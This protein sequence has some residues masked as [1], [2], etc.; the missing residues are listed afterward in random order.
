MEASK[1][2]EGLK[3]TYLIGRHLTTRRVNPSV[4]VHY[5]EYSLVNNGKHEG[6]LYMPCKSNLNYLLTGLFFDWKW[7]YEGNKEIDKKDFDMLRHIFNSQKEYKL[8]RDTMKQ[9]KKLKEKKAK[10]W[11]RE[12]VKILAL[13]N[14]LRGK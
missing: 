5:S 14:L 9:I 12:Q 1:F 7:D 13:R 2:K 3:L 6:Y 11:L 4:T 8:W 10:E